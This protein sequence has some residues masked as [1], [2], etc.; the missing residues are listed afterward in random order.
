M[1]SSNKTKNIGKISAS[2]FDGKANYDFHQIR[3]NSEDEKQEEQRCDIATED[4]MSCVL[5]FNTSE[6]NNDSARDDDVSTTEMKNEPLQPSKRNIEIDKEITSNQHTFFLSK[7]EK[8]LKENIEK[9]QGEMNPQCAETLV[10]M[11]NIFLSRSREPDNEEPAKDARRAKACFMVASTVYRKNS[12][13]E[14]EQEAKQSRNKAR[15]LEAE[16]T[17]AHL[18]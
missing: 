8:R 15:E 4:T 17:Q 16:F 18:E 13:H 14:K 7:L 10:Q 1:K 5:S 11:G 9:S 2:E 12:M 6:S 3:K